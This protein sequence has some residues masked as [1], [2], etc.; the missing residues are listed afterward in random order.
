M[1]KQVP[2]PRRKE[3]Q[4]W[5][6]WVGAAPRGQKAAR[7]AD[8]SA[9]CAAEPPHRRGVAER[10]RRGLHQSSLPNDLRER[11]GSHGKLRASSCALFMCTALCFFS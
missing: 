2:R 1:R 6:Q 3:W 7:H 11:V 9:E 4:A 5:L 10:A 8:G